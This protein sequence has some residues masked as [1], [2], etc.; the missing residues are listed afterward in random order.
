MLT[1]WYAGDFTRPPEYP[2]VADCTP[3]TCSNTACTPQQQ[4]P[5]TTAA[6]VSALLASATSRP[7]LGNS[8]ALGVS[9]GRAPRLRMAVHPKNATTTAIASDFPRYGLCIGLWTFPKYYVKR[10]SLDARECPH[11]RKRSSQKRR[12]QRDTSIA[13]NL[14]PTAGIMWTSKLRR[15]SPHEMKFNSYRDALRSPPI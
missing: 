1:N 12:G 4:P 15:R 13:W 8:E 14:S 3:F 6:S 11:G 10:L 7:G 5:A 2:D 9:A